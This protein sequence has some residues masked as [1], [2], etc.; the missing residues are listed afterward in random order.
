MASAT[1]IG[2]TETYCT[3]SL[4]A[5]EFILELKST[6]KQCNNNNKARD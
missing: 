2:L 6:F 3:P 4:D 5:T 1:T